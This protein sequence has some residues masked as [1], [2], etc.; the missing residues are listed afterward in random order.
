MYKYLS[1]KSHK[2]PYFLFCVWIFLPLWIFLPHS[3]RDLATQNIF[4]LS[5]IGDDLC[6]RASFL[7]TYQILTVP[8][9]YLFN[10]NYLAR[11]YSGWISGVSNKKWCFECSSA[12]IVCLFC[13]NEIRIKGSVIHPKEWRSASIFHVLAFPPTIFTK[14]IHIVHIHAENPSP[15]SVFFWC[16]S[17]LFMKNTGN[18]TSQLAYFEW[19]VPNSIRA[20]GSGKTKLYW[21][22][23]PT[24]FFS[25]VI[26]IFILFFI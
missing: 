19:N 25:K 8:P 9:Y 4:S 15:Y 17:R 10:L 11:C 7:I 5:N 24:V 3:K 16:V 22:L 26:F 13:L 21:L 18:F 23:L 14:V 6:Q 2:I 20:I 12:G 1:F